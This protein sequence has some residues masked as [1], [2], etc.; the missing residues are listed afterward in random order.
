VV[1]ADAKIGEPSPGVARR[2]VR[3]DAARG[4]AVLRQPAEH[5]DLVPDDRGAHLGPRLG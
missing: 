3:V 4:A 1:N 2:R 5:D